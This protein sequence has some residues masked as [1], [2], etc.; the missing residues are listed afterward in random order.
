MNRRAETET[1]DVLSGSFDPGIAVIPPGTRLGSRYV[2]RDALGIGGSSVVYAADDSLTSRAVAVKVLRP[3]RSTETAL[4][5]FRNEALIAQGIDCP[6]IVR[7]FDYAEGPPTYLVMELAREGSLRQALKDGP[8]PIGRAIE[9]A[10]QVLRA[11]SAL[12]DRFIIHCDV[13]PGNILI[14]AGARVVLGDFGLARQTSECADVCSSQGVIGTLEYL[15]PEQALGRGLD[16]RTDLYALGIV[17]FEMLTGAVPHRRASALGTLLAHIQEPAPNVRKL[18]PTT[19]QWLS[20]LIACLLDK[21][22]RKRFDSASAVLHDLPQHD[23]E[24]LRTCICDCTESWQTGAHSCHD[25]RSK[26]A[27]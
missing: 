23:T 10:G 18:R 4:V 1:I 26:L 14:D 3:D 22:P 11:L 24:S 19:P 15:A 7:V 9:I 20:E 21:Q 12:H 25:V 8:L 6:H 16:A 17:L 27:I 5:R 2:I 13:K